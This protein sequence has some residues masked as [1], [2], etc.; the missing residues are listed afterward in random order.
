M[1][2]AKLIFVFILCSLI[3][4]A[5]TNS[6]KKSAAWAAFEAGATILIETVKGAVKQPFEDESLTHFVVDDVLTKTN[7]IPS[8]WKP[9]SYISGALCTAVAIPVDM[10]VGAVKGFFNGITSIVE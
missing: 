8:E 6:V 3:S 1:Q 4:Q 2:I 5:K 7:E 10:S 9:V